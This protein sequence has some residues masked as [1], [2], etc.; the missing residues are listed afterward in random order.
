MP[1]AK[2][3]RLRRIATPESLGIQASLRDAMLIA[4]ANTGI[5]MPAYTSIEML[6]YTGIK[7]PA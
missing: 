2:I 1:L 4:L 5:E 6:A 7:M 3:M